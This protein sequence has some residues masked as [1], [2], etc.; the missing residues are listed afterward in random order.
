MSYME[1]AANVQSYANCAPNGQ[2]V[3]KMCEQIL[4]ALSGT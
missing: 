4:P 2:R 3:W 1:R